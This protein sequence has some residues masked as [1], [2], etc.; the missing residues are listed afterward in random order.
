MPKHNC[1]GGRF[2]NVI[3]TLDMIDIDRQLIRSFWSHKIA[4]KKIT[5]FYLLEIIVTKYFYFRISSKSNVLFSTLYS[6][7]L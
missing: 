1:H 5:V 6:T 3:C 2:L 4:K 7:D